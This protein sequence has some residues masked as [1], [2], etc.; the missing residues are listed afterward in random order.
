MRRKGTSTIGVLVVGVWLGSLLAS[1]QA[2]A[3]VVPD[4]S[5]VPV[6]TQTETFADPAA[7]GVPTNEIR[8]YATSTA[9]TSGGKH[10]PTEQWAQV[11]TSSTSGNTDA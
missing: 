7:V 5:V 3:Y 8:F 9:S 11:G 10:I 1:D 6:Y 2:S 4:G